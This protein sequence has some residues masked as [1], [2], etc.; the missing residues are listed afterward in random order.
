M[1]PRNAQLYC[2]FA[3][4][5]RFCKIITPLIQDKTFYIHIHLNI[6][7]QFYIDKIYQIFYLLLL[8]CMASLKM[9][10]WHIARFHCCF[11]VHMHF[12]KII[13]S[14]IRDLIFCIYIHLIIFKMLYIDQIYWIFHLLSLWHEKHDIL[15]SLPFICGFEKI[16]PPLIRDMT[17]YTQIHL[18]IIKKVLHR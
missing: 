3:V 17:F 9:L 16:I 11:A 6:I 13:T 12:C 8:D 10:S 1:V 4:Y 7:K 15:A 2:L 5:M 18:N 14:L